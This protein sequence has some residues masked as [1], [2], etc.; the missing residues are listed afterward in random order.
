MAYPPL[1][2]Q[3]IVFGQQIDIHTHTAEVLDAIAGAGFGAIEAGVDFHAEDPATW[4]AELD[5]RG[6]RM[7]GLHGGLDQDLEQ[8]LRLLEAYGAHDLCISSLGGWENVLYDNYMRDIERL[9]QMGRACK[10]R[11]VHVHYHN[12]SYE[13]CPTNEGSSGM[14]LIMA[15]VDPQAADL[16]V[17]VAWVRIGGQDPAL[18]LRTHAHQIGYVHL[19]DYVGNRHW[20]ELGYGLVD[21]YSVMKALAEL[22]CVRWAVYEQDTSTRSAAESCALS[23]RYLVDTFGY[24]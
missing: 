11:G 1:G 5:A 17:D 10:A 6:L 12:H 20:V 7:A 2:A 23:H 3:L 24:G 16:C 9:N 15:N 19:K 22:P 18:F 4:K 14:E 21:L 8:T 13:F